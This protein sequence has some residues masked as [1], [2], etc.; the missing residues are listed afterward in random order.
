MSRTNESANL[1]KHD[2]VETKICGPE[3]GNG[4]FKIQPSA[5]VGDVENSQRTQDQ[6]TFS[7]RDGSTGMFVHQDC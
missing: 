2:M 5:G 7:L 4:R 3:L 6:H 1:L